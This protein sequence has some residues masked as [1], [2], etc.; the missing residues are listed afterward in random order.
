MG[1][2]EARRSRS[3]ERAA[4]GEPPDPRRGPGPGRPTAVAL[5]VVA[6]LGTA[7]VAGAGT[8]EPPSLGDDFVGKAH[9]VRYSFDSRLADAGQVEAGCGSQSWHLAG[10][11]AAIGGTPSEAR[12]SAVRPINFGDTDGKADDGWFVVGGGSLGAPA[13]SGAIC[14]RSAKL[15]YRIQQVPPSTADLR[16]AKLSCGGRGWHVT[17]GSA[18]IGTA[19]SWVGSS[20]PYDGPD[21]GHVPDDGWKG[22]LLDLGSGGFTLHVICTRGD[23][24]TYRRG[25]PGTIGGS[26]DLTRKARCPRSAS[27]IGGGGRVGGLINRGRVYSTMPYDG[28]DPGGVPDDGWRVS[29]QNLSSGEERSL[30][31]FAICLR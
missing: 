22:H 4:R 31:A 16:T 12:L 1:R 15:R 7:A 30:T 19:N 3:R 24:V 6:M 29:A 20:Y 11:G 21:R 23:E 5:T 8:D 26:D 9:G 28:P 14:V 10:G 2:P 13:S 25:K 17:G 18:F 27:V